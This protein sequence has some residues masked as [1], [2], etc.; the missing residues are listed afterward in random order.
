MQFV[1]V[2]SYRDQDALC[3]YIRVP[4]V[5]ILPEIHIFLYGR[6][7]AF[8]LYAAVHPELDAPVAEDALQVFFAFRLFWTMEERC[9]E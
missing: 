5:Q 7:R 1:D 4:T 8:H 2:V 3:Q 6:K 9:M